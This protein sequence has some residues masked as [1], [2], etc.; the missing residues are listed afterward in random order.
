MTIKEQAAALVE[1]VLA[2]T[3]TADDAR[4]EWPLP[5]G[6]STLEYAYHQLYHYE[7]DEDIR[8]RDDRYRE[9]QVRQM[10]GLV[11]LLRA[12]LP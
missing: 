2:G 7:D 8:A 6:D 12:E 10:K 5:N 9:W 1:Q 11:S 3:K 4:G